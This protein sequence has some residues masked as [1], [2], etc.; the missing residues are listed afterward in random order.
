MTAVQT[1]PFP[2]SDTNKRYHTY[3]YYLKHKYGTKCAR[4]PIDAG[5]SCP[6]RERTHHGDS[7]S[8]GRGCIYCSARGSGDFCS[9]P[10]LPPRVQFAKAYDRL[11]QKWNTTAE[12]E[13]HL[14]AIPYFQAFTN[15]YAPLDTLK[16]L[17][18]EALHYTDAHGNPVHI[19]ALSIATRPDCLPPDVVSYLAELNH[20]VDIT[21][22]LG[23]QSAHDKTLQRIGRGHDAAAF[24]S[25][26]RRLKEA[27]IA[28]CVHIING[29]P[30]ENTEDMLETARL[31]SG[32]QPDFLKIHMLHVLRGTPLESQYIAAQDDI[33]AQDGIAVQTMEKQ[34]AENAIPL[35][36]L[37]EYTDIVCRQLE[38]LPPA[39]VICRL[40]GDGASED[41]I[42]PLWVKNKRAV[43]A[44]IDKTLAARDT[45][46]GKE[47]SGP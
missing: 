7:E 29:L 21:V 3:D 45:Y 38:L 43:L 44:Q 35:L 8:N 18:E 10:L 24:L 27:G 36:T 39:T 25:G 6:N 41:L 2:Y 4:I 46:Q 22:E 42:A 19:P 9:S 30:G 12:G 28:V 26:Y 14:P 47:F 17:Y 32:L 11:C 5:F 13:K 37:L 15:T 20:R 16:T 23:L 33:A 1:S 40:T 34:N 31:L